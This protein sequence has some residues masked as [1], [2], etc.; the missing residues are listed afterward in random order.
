[1]NISSSPAFTANILFKTIDEK[2]LNVIQAELAK[3]I[4][5][6]QDVL[7]SIHRPE[8]SGDCGWGAMPGVHFMNGQD[9]LL[10]NKIKAGLDAAGVD[11]SGVDKGFRD[12]AQSIDVSPDRSNESVW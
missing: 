10:R 9:L 12:A 11:S 8:N 4:E 3:P 1:M 6:N 5:D 7:S 2:A